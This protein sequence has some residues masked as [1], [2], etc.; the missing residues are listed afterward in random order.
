MFHHVDAPK[1]IIHITDQAFFEA[2]DLELP[3]LETV[4]KA[5]QN[6]DYDT[7]FSAFWQHFLTRKTPIDPISQTQSELHA[8]IKSNRELADILVNGG[9]YTFGQVTLD[10]S[11]S[12]D[13]NANFGDQS[14]YG[15]HYL[16]WLEPLPYAALETGDQKY[17]ETYLALVRQWYAVRDQITG[18]RPMHPVFYELGLAGRSRRFLDFLYTVQYLNLQHL[19]TPDDAR[20]FFKS[21]LGAGR[22][23]TLEQTTKGYRKGNWQLFGV[24]S[25]LTIGFN[26]PEFQ[27]SEH[28]RVVG[29]DYLEQ[30][31]EQDYYADGGHSERCYSY[32]I[33]CLRHL[34]ETTRLLE[35]NP[36]LAPTQRLNWRE[37]AE[38][39]FYW[40]LKMAGPAGAFPGIN[41]STF[42]NGSDVLKRGAEFTGNQA[43]LYPIRHSIQTDPISEPDFTSVQLEASEFCVMRAGWEPDDPFLI[44]NHGQ[45]PGGH[46]HMGILDFNLYAHNTPLVADVGRFGPYDG[47]FDLFFRSEQAHNHIVVEGAI[48]K[49]AEVR[50]ENIHFSTSENFDFFSGQHRAYEET[51]NVL[52]ERRILFLKPWGFLISDTASAPP[53]RKSY[54]WYLHS[55]F[56]FIKQ[57]THAIAEQ[58]HTGL[59]VVPADP[60]QLQYAH[61]GIDYLEDMV[62]E[63]PLYSGQQNAEWLN[64]YFLALRGWSVSNAITPFDVLLCPYQGT[65]PNATITQIECK[66]EGEAP[67]PTLP[68]VLEIKTDDRK[69]HVFHSTT[70]VTISTQNITF[71]GHIAAIEYN[72]NRPVK[73][74][75]YLGDKLTIDGK[76]I[77]LSQTEID[78]S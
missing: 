71:S 17:I 50:G 22:W 46:S 21:L 69:L 16:G 36:E 8:H 64:R 31:M 13:F 15:F 4:Q 70:G 24:W 40:F 9:T 60:K 51:A 53:R 38:R 7:A 61:Q 74:F 72:K 48:S 75:T 76:D 44:M 33:G 58:D 26:L 28:F 78:L 66:V 63:T 62:H 73:A 52:I 12:I 77:D 23:L 14:K 34:E 29:A 41:D 6:N 45:H 55:I 57:D 35:S 25:L 37:Y 1:K 20:I 30:H 54:L 27:E 49:R 47:P 3:G 11:D 65:Q 32:G 56:P 5:V 19:I 2:L 39:A 18:E 68:R 67:A 59:L 43:F 10:F 42:M